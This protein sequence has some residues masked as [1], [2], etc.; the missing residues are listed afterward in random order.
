MKSKLGYIKFVL[1]LA[2]MAFLYGF[3]EKRHSQRKLTGSEVHFTDNENLYV[4]VDAVNKLLIQNEEANANLGQETLDLNKVETLLNSHDMIENAEVF[5]RLDG[6]LS[7]IVTQRKPIGRAVGNTSFYLDKNGEVMPLSENFSARVPLMLGFDESNILTAYPLVSYIKNDSFLSKHI[8]TIQR[9][10]NGRY[11]LKLRKADFVVYF[12][13]IKN[14]ALKFN[15][16]KAFYKKA[17]KDK[18]LDTYKRVN[19]QFGNQVV[20]TKK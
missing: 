2:L 3:A 8:T 10:E 6:K 5:L 7:A 4:T 12:G 13:E 20:C 16:F 15:N 11:E 9:L 1:L 18:K 14:I 19:L 17:L